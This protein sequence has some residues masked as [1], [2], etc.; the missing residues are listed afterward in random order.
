MNLITKLSCLLLALLFISGCSH[1]STDVAAPGPPTAEDLRIARQAMA[2]GDVGL[3]LR[4]G[5]KQDVI[6]AE[7]RKKRLSAPLDAAT[8][9]AL[10]HSGA[11]PALI[12]AMKAPE[13]VLTATQRQAFDNFA[14]EK[15]QRAQQEASSRQQATVA[16][17]QAENEDRQRRAAMLQQTVQN[18]RVAEY[19]DQAYQQNWDAY[20]RQKE[21]LEK[22]I[23][24]LQNQINLRRSNG[25]R[26]NNLVEANQEL[27]RLNEQLRHLPT[28]ALR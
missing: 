13:N 21:Y 8:E 27:D 16:A 15:T 18:A 20:K 12:A 2:P 7:V 26:E 23:A 1:S 25:Y 10:L 6:I 3:L 19:K 28:P 4:G 11:S 9:D 14:A 22:R 24:S 5:Y 17:Q